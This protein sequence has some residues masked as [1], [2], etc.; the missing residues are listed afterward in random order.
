VRV[1]GRGDDGRELI[2]FELF[3]GLDEHDQRFRS[4][5]GLANRMLERIALPGELL[6][7][8]NGEHDL[9]GEGLEVALLVGR[10]GLHDHAMVG[11]RRG[12]LLAKLALNRAAAWNLDDQLRFFGHGRTV[13]RRPRAYFFFFFFLFVLGNFSVAGAEQ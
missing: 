10:P 13:S 3:C 9:A 8:G 7:P 11:E 6:G 12:R 1:L 2:V 5:A 4:R